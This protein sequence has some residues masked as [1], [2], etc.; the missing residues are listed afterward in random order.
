M[1]NSASDTTAACPRSTRWWVAALKTSTTRAR[2][3]RCRSRSGS[4]SSSEK[5]R[6]CRHDGFATGQDHQR[7]TLAGVCIAA[8]RES[9]VWLRAPLPYLL[10]AAKSQLR[11]PRRSRERGARHRNPLRCTCL[12]GD[13][14]R[15]DSGP[16]LA[17]ETWSDYFAA[18]ARRWRFP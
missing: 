18:D 7:S 5:E 14:L 2:A 13:D 16:L 10:V 17:A 9:I 6:L 12:V 1:D 8:G 3:G 15:R 4:A 11:A